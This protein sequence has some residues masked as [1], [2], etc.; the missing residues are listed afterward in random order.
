MDKT[1]LLNSWQKA[2]SFSRI[3]AALALPVVVLLVGNMLEEPIRQ[4]ESSMRLM[5]IAAGVLQA[6]GKNLK[7]SEIG[8]R[9]W[10]ISVIEK[11]S[12]IPFPKEIKADLESGKTQLPMNMSSAQTIVNPATG[13]WGVVFGGDKEKTAAQ[14]EIKNANEKWKLTEPRIYLRRGMYRSVSFS[15]D[16]TEA[17]EML[18]IARAVI[19]QRQPYLVNLNSWCPVSR[20]GSDGIV[21]CE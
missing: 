5:E 21:V 11:H 17:Q 7:E 2:E 8:A 3:I 18:R 6:D 10:A 12:G 13:P 4:R 19:P 15:A 16:Q 14:D 1:E 9:K 20:S